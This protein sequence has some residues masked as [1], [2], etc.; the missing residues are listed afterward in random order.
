MLQC[1]HSLHEAPNLVHNKSI[2]SVNCNIETISTSTAF[3]HGR[4]RNENY[5]DLYKR[6]KHFVEERK[7]KIYFL[8]MS[9]NV[10]SVLGFR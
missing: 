5:P 3:M 2:L 4:N 9:L 1:L 7:G 6:R 10:P 8:R